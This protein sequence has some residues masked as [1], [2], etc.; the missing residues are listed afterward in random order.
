M[1]EFAPRGSNEM[2][3]ELYFIIQVVCVWKRVGHC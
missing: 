1:L 2:S 3:E